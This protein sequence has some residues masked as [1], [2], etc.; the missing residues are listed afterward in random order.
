LASPLSRPQGVA[1]VFSAFA[2]GPRGRGEVA[3]LAAVLSAALPLPASAQNLP[4]LAVSD[5]T[6]SR[7]PV[8]GVVVVATARLTNVGSSSSGSFN[9]KWFVNGAQV[10]YGGHASLA[11][12]Q[13]STGNVQLPWTM[14]SGDTL[15]R[16][17][18]DVDG[19]V[20]EE[21]EANNSYQ[22]LVRNGT[23]VP[24]ADLRVEGMSFD[25]PPR[26]GEETVVTA[27][28]RN[29][30]QASSGV[31]NVRWRLDGVEIA[32]G[33]HSSLGPGQLSDDNV[34][35][36]WTPTSPGSHRLRFEADISGH[37]L[38]SNRPT[39]TSWEATTHRGVA[40]L[41]P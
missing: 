40:V 22:V 17:D 14:S 18:A 26:V 16:F 34:R 27:R 41:P 31:F 4:D 39:T 10:G 37:V 11:P 19:H 36:Y 35:L 9:V 12:G 33:S 21:G 29:A 25:S 5:I 23:E 28:L 15:F 30:G 2:R 20:E 38:E 32:A 3:A 13:T 1:Y 7:A 8:P 6:F 24:L